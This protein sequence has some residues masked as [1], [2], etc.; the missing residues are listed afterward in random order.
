METD[1]VERKYWTDAYFNK[2][3]SYAEWASKDVEMW[4][5]QDA[6]HDRILACIDGLSPMPG[7][8]E[9]LET[10]LSQSH[11]MGIISGSL[12]VAFEK[13]YPSWRRY[14]KHVFLNRLEFSPEGKLTGVIPTPYDIEHKATG[15]REM[16]HRTGVPLTHTVFIGDN[17]NDVEVAR[18]AGCSIAFNCK[19][20]EL[21]EVSD[22]LI[23]GDDLRDILP[24]IES[25]AAGVQ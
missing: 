16:A 21:A 18:L 8:G 6:D 9:T 23:P 1:P 10:L 17:F 19:S 4:M 11:T 5:E 24:I 20:D 14:F 3:I 13:V 22:H 12:D 15:L 2:E 7:A 25:F